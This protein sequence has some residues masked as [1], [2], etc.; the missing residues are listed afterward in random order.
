M[1]VQAPLSVPLV[2][3]ENGSIDPFFLSFI[4]LS[5]GEYRLSSN[6]A[7][8]VFSQWRECCP[9][10]SPLLHIEFMAVHPCSA[11]RL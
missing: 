8:L 11:K 10:E 6:G 1:S 9:G 2:R 5:T 7:I 3:N 4:F